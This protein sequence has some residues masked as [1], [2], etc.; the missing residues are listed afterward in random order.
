MF[1]GVISIKNTISIHPLYGLTD[2]NSNKIPRMI[3]I[4]PVRYT[5]CVLKGITAGTIIDIPL[6]NIKCPAAVK[7]NIKHIARF[8]PKDKFQSPVVNLEMT[9]KATNTAINKINGFI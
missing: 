3:S 7:H 6:V 9:I 1:A 2:G 5:N 4:T 8:P